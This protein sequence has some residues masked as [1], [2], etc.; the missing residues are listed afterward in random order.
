MTRLLPALLLLFCLAAPG[1]G[2]DSIT[3]LPAPETPKPCGSRPIE[4]ARMPWPSAAILAEIHKRLLEQ[5][6][7]C[8]VEIVAGDLAGTGSSM[9]AT[10]APTVA[11][12][13]WI[14]RIADIWNAGVKAEKVRQ[15]APSYDMPVLE[16]WFIPGYVAETHPELTDLAAFKAYADIFAGHGGRL[17][18]ISCPQD[19][20]CALI[21]RNLIAAAGLKDR[22]D[23]VTPADRFEMDRLI[24][25]AV[26]RKQPFAFYY[27][28]PNAIIS[29]FA[30]RAI[31]L[32][33]YDHDAFQCLGRQVCALGKV[34]GFAPEPVVVAVSDWVFTDLPLLAGYF[35]RATMP[36]AAM[37][38]MLMQL[39][40]AEGGTVDSIADR[41]V[42]E[43][44][45][46]W[47]RWVG[48][49]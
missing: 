46:I 35:S 23:V 8:T 11:P 18:F 20:G 34:S 16:G 33:P 15:A 28:Q 5:H 13:L 7:G 47:D 26:S 6:F 2:Q 14:A 22:L 42:R 27:W 3:V 10:G 45:D 19:W 29:Q 41:F 32:G 25:E 4:I 48:T 9:G 37:D 38:A 39:D 49:P 43:R 31:D 21:N 40:E 12:E 30:F 24:A 17:K 36:V 1:F 44:R